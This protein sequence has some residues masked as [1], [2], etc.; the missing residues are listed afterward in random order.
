MKTVIPR[1]ILT[2]CRR[3]GESVRSVGPTRIR[4]PFVPRH[5]L[6]APPN[7]SQLTWPLLTLRL[8]RLF[9]CQILRPNP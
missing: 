6:A 7:E 9:L 2:L 4:G 3:E 8:N 5:A 1:M